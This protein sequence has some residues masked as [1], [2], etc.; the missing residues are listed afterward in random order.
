MTRLQLGNISPHIWRV[1]RSWM[2][3]RAEH[4]FNHGC[5]SEVLP[6]QPCTYLENETCYMF[7]HAADWI[8]TRHKIP[9]RPLFTHIGR[10]A[11]MSPTIGNLS[12]ISIRRYGC[13][14]HHHVLRHGNFTMLAALPWP[15][16]G[17][18]QVLE[19]CQISLQLW[20]LRFSIY[21][22]WWLA[23]RYLPW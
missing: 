10:R 12:C 3:F 7:T 20:H 15:R 9:S 19:I 5:R 18:G 11:R 4:G 2:C 6:S 8:N 17:L 16:R 14:N 23:F 13:G 1:W 22:V 21:S